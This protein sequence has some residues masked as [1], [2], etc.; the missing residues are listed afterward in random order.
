MKKNTLLCILVSFVFLFLSCTANTPESE[1]YTLSYPG[2]RWGMTPEE[3]FKA[4]KPD[5]SDFV[6][7]RTFET[8]VAPVY[9]MVLYTTLFGAEAQTTFE[10]YDFSGN[11]HYQLDEIIAVFPQNAD[12]DSVKNAMVSNYGMP[13]SEDLSLVKLTWESVG[14]LQD[15]LS[16]KDKELF[17]TNNPSRLSEPA[18]TIKLFTYGG[19][20]DFL[21]YK[22]EPTTNY[23]Q[24]SS[25]A[26]MR[27]GSW[28]DDNDI[29]EQAS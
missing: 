13:T 11:G 9:V 27:S 24:F 15:F 29:P 5:E 12:M 2:T 18:T 23:L 28:F 1:P 19:I 26:Y 16:E 7:E 20:Y 8:S 6:E 17:I 10:F 3:A 25:N 14:Q 4:L 22:D 21:T